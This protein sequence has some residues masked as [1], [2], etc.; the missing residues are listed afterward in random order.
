[1]GPV[2]NFCTPRYGRKV[3]A[4]KGAAGMSRPPLT[5][6]KHSRRGGRLFILGVDP[7]KSKILGLLASRAPLIRF[8]RALAG[9]DYFN[10]LTSERKVTRMS[11][12]RPTIRFERKQGARSEGLDCAIYAIAAR[13]ALTLDLERREEELAAARPQPATPAP[14]VIQSQWMSR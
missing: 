6:A 1:M 14:A 10:Q 5:L 12:G 2:L 7:L 3:L 11:R 4:G 13:A 9:T 8:A